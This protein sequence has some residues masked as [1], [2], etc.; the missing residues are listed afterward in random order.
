[1]RR[2]ALA[3]GIALALVLASIP[4]L[5]VLNSHSKPSGAV[6]M[7]LPLPEL[8]ITVNGR[9][10]YAGPD[11][12]TSNFIQFMGVALAAKRDVALTSYSGSSFSLT[13]SVSVGS[14]TES[15]ADF[16]FTSGS[17]IFIYGNCPYIMIPAYDFVYYAKLGLMYNGY[18]RYIIEGMFV[19]LGNGSASFTRDAY[20]LSRE[21]VRAS[22][23]TSYGYNSTGS[24]FDVVSSLSVP[25]S[26]NL[27]EVGVVLRL[28]DP[29][30]YSTARDNILANPYVDVLL[31]Y[32]V[33][34]SPVTLNAGDTVAVRYRF[35]LPKPF[36]VQMAKWLRLWLPSSIDYDKP[37]Q[38][39]V[40][41]TT[42]VVTLKYQA[43]ELR[44]TCP[45]TQAAYNNRSVVAG[46]FIQG[47]EPSRQVYLAYGNGN[48]AWSV[49]DKDVYNPLGRAP[50]LSAVAS[51]NSL[52]LVFYIN[53][54]GSTDMHITELALQVNTTNA[55]GVW[56][57]VTL[58]RWTVDY[59]IPAG[60][61][62][63]IAVRVATP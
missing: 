43:I 47:T 25:A 45:H 46:F 18:I 28:R 15:Y 29:M 32:T 16:F 13:R 56:R 8:T 5:L 17:Q 58:A 51:G 4:A 50:L 42:G 11:P 41:A 62:V 21:V 19:V 2:K 61:G 63:H 12:P 37:I 26:F 35:Y 40:N 33:L 60:S 20:A 48:N 44:N 10:V 9:T 3:L 6:E 55:S 7:S 1:M 59:T 34:P 27:K 38:E 49:W 22:A 14:N 39:S 31:L 57:L 30:Y 23:G 52:S 53:N 36:T 24:W 54:P